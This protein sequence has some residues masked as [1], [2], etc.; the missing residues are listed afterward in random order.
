VKRI[1]FILAFLA[2]IGAGWYARLIHFYQHWFDTHLLGTVWTPAKEKQL[3]EIVRQPF[4]YCGEGSTSKAYVS[5]DGRF[6]IKLFLNNSFKSHYWQNFPFLR[7]LANK[8]KEL[9]CKYN[10]SFGAINAYQYIPEES[11]MVFYQF[12]RPR[13]LFSHPILLRE[14]DGTLSEFDLNES[15]YII[16]KKAVIVSEYFSA[17]LS[18]GNLE[19][20]YSGITKILELVKTLYDQGI[21]LVVLQFLDN[22]GFVGDEPIRIDVEHVCYDPKWKEKGK[23]HLQKQLPAFRKWIVNN[24]P[25]EVVSHFDGEVQRIFGL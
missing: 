14:S 22:F 10:R 12:I 18:N 15:E 21:V 24:A 13:N 7:D 20:V 17:H 1:L 2:L 3:A 8:R 5:E 6:V 23:E 19:K 4:R 25:E 11:G 9:R 16:Q